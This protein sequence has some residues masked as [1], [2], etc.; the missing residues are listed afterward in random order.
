MYKLLLPPLRWPLCRLTSLVLFWCS[1]FVAVC[2]F[3]ALF[4]LSLSN[5]GPVHERNHQTYVHA[6]AVWFG[7]ACKQQPQQFICVHCNITRRPAT[8]NVHTQSQTETAEAVLAAF[9]VVALVVGCVTNS[10]LFEP[11]CVSFLESFVH[12][13]VDYQEVWLLVSAVV[14]LFFFSLVCFY[15]GPYRSY[16]RFLHSYHLATYIPPVTS[17]T[18]DQAVPISMDDTT[19]GE[20]LYPTDPDEDSEERQR[21]AAAAVNQ[22][23]YRGNRVRYYGETTMQK[24]PEIGKDDAFFQHIDHHA[25]RRT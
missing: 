4:Y 1:L 2:L 16:L 17:Y 23:L 20:R 6:K 7:E 8:M 15:C 22:L 10:T 13:A 18:Y 25:Y 5:Y 19:P 3:F 9:P 14:V 12:L 21:Y 11:K 24:V